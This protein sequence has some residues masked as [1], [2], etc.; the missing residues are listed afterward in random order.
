LEA[1]GIVDKLGPDCS[2]KWKRGDRVMALLP[3]GGNAE[4]VACREECL[5]NIPK[6]MSFIKAAAIPEVWL[7][8]YQLLH[9]V[10]MFNFDYTASTNISTT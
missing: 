2:Q 10:G 1:V 5:I 9:T 8:A 3:G 4:F 7:T 6:T